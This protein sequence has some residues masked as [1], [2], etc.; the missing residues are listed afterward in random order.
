[1]LTEWALECV[2][3]QGVYKI[4]TTMQ[5]RSPRDGCNTGWQNPAGQ[6]FG[7]LVSIIKIQSHF[8]N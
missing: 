1:M 2:Y 8:L 7:K 6:Q 3:T 5:A 4:P